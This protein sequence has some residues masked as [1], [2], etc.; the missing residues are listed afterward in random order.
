MFHRPR[1]RDWSPLATQQL[2]LRN[3]IQISGH[4]I[5]AD[6]KSIIYYTLH[7]TTMSA[8]FF[9]SERLEAHPTIIW[10]EINC[11]AIVKST[12][13]FVCIRMWQVLT[14]HHQTDKVGVTQLR[15]EV[16]ES[17]QGPSVTTQALSEQHSTD[18]TNS[19]DQSRTQ[20]GDADAKT[21]TEHTPDRVM[22]L[23]GVYFS[24]LVPITKRTDVRLAPNALVFHI[25]GGFFT[26]A[27]Y[28][29]PESVPRQ[30]NYFLP[31]G[32]AIY[33][34]I[35][36][37]TTGKSSPDLIT[38]PCD[39]RPCE[40]MALKIRFLTRTFYKQ[41][42]R[43]SY[44][45]DKLLLLQEKQRRFRY[46]CDISKEVIDR[47]CM[48]SAFC[49]NLQLIAN[50]ALVYRTPPRGNPSM[51]R[52][53]NRLLSPQ[54]EQPKPEVLLR[55]QEL[56][57]Q[58]EMVRFRC[59][60]L[61]QERDHHK[62]N[63]RQLRAQNG[64]ISDENIDNGSWLMANYRGL[65]RDRVLA[66]EQRDEFLRQRQM[67]D[68]VSALLFR[69]RKELLYQLKDIY[70]VECD[71]DRRFYKINGIYLPNADAYSEFSV[72]SL[73][74]PSN[75]SVALGYVAHLVMLCSAILN[76]P[77]RYVTLTVTIFFW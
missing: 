27:E 35:V 58:V 8:P 53:L 19:L 2:R 60:F 73:T 50:K 32:I 77:L 9:T 36:D 76:I 10:P 64:R 25:H 11:P 39:D 3:L 7:F 23:W 38:F 33:L 13:Q 52:T 41:E 69:R 22:F 18:G 40:P 56:R 16:A 63:L 55:A 68:N 1:C 42:I 43:P 15:K 29:L 4:N 12:S 26:S 46:K 72:Q 44:N 6:S 37:Q 66:A 65:K 24:G 49:L 59:R 62:V 75:I 34:A 28:L 57:R 51:G 5:A 17:S 14:S 30:I 20:G 21:T 74:T 31:A 71:L 61:T 45:V 67:L 48:K 47:I 70:A 54:P